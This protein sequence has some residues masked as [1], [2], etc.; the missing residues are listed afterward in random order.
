MVKTSGYLGKSGQLYGDHTRSGKHYVYQHINSET[1]EVFY[2]GLGRFNRCNQVK[3]RNKFWKRYT[4]KHAYFVKIIAS[5]LSRKEAAQIEINLIRELKPRCNLTS[6]GEQGTLLGRRVHAF[7]KDG[8]LFKSFET[9]SEA[10]S[11]FGVLPNDSRIPRCLNGCRQR[12]KGFMWSKS[13]TE[14]P[15]YRKRKAKAKTVHQYDL[16]GKWVASFSS[17][18]DANVPTRTGIYGVLD[19]QRSYR[20]SFWRSE[21]TDKIDVQILKPALVASKKV[22]CTKTSKVYSSIAQACKDKK[23]KHQ[24]VSKKLRGLLTNNTGLILYGD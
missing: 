2:V 19:S 9:I 23:L 5:Y 21:K 18:K 17:P 7:T 22:L 6:G 1:L 10:N 20:G 12:F 4:H 24:T 11:F 15:I 14:I 8:E 16:S 13:L 3:Q